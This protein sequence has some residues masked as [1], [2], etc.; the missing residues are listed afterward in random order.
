MN[1]DIALLSTD[2]LASA[3]PYV[4]TGPGDLDATIVTTEALGDLEGF[5]EDQLEAAAQEWVE[6]PEGEAFI[7]DLPWDIVDPRFQHARSVTD[8][9]ITA[10]RFEAADERSIDVSVDVEE[11]KDGFDERVAA[12]RAAI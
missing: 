9:E 3:G 1:D 11:S 8:F 12:E 10:V 5:D 2:E 7:A 6:S 4:N